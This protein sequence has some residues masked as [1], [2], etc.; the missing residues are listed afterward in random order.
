MEAKPQGPPWPVRFPHL[1][2]DFR[3]PRSP[4]L[5]LEIRRKHRRMS[6]S[7]RFTCFYSHP[8]VSRF[9]ANLNPSQLFLR[10][11]EIC[12]FVWGETCMF[13][14]SHVCFP[15]DLFRFFF[16]VSPANLNPCHVLL[17]P[18]NHHPSPFSSI[19]FCCGTWEAPDPRGLP[20]ITIHSPFM[21]SWTLNIGLNP[22]HLAISVSPFV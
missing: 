15:S 12:M 20:P 10:K 6:Y 5:C 21:P 11:R 22:N 9:L 1:L 18:R 19:L 7:F 3:P 13:L 2:L 4:S 16:A 14:L 8:G 17:S